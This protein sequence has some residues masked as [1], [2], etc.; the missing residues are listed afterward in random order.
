[1]RELEEWARSLTAHPTVTFFSEPSAATLLSGF[2]RRRSHRPGDDP[3]LQ[4]ARADGFDVF[5]ECTI[6][7]LLTDGKRVVGHSI[8]ARAGSFV[9][10]ESKAVVMATV[11]SA[12]LE[13]YFK[14]VDYP[15][16]AWSG[17]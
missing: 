8:L 6:I 9:V 11:V 13:R 16:T 2:A 17:L 15:A 12:G 4:D 10:A 5:M 3:T 14:F 1:V 7:R